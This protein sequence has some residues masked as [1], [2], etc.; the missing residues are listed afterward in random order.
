MVSVHF[1]D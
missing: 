1:T